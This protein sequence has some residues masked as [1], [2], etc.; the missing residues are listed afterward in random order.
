M[1]PHYKLK[2]ELLKGADAVWW[3][4]MIVVTGSDLRPERSGQVAPSRSPCSHLVFPLRRRV[5]VSKTTIQT[6]AA[7]LSLSGTCV[8]LFGVRE[9]PAACGIVELGCMYGGSLQALW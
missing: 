6:S 3:R 1:T 8:L 4:K 5:S 7:S 2:P 9:W